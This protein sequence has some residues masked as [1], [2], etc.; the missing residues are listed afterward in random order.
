[1]NFDK[2]VL[3]LCHGLEYNRGGW[4]G[5]FFPPSWSIIFTGGVIISNILY[6]NRY[7]ISMYK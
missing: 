5:W 2:D 1:M 3:S 7:A 6:N 4:V